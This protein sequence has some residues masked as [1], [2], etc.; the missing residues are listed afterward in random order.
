MAVK[1]VRHQFSSSW[2]IF[3]SCGVADTVQNFPDDS[4]FF[5]SD[6]ASEKYKEV[7]FESQRDET[8]DRTDTGAFLERIN[9]FWIPFIRISFQSQAK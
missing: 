2:E 6:C 9:T 3:P 7:D 5:V 4:N 1:T 8:A